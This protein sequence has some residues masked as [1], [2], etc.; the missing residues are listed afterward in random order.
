MIQTAPHPRLAAPKET[1]ESAVSRL[2]QIEV[3]PA[4]PE[5]EPVVANLLELYMHDFSEFLDVEL[6]T[7]G[8]FVYPHLS[9]YWLEPDR[10]LFLVTVDGRLAGVILVKKESG[11]RDNEAAWDMA[12]FFVVRKYR[13]RGVG[14]EAAHR[15][16][17][18][19][20]GRWQVRVMESNRPALGFW[21]RAIA[22]FAGAASQSVRIENGG[23][24]WTVF[25]F[26]SPRSE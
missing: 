9:S 23:R 10:H 7:D 6:G 21:D 26:E 14:T 19:L 12:E 8:R 20:P 5:Q 4:A 13:R 3:T 16:W 25:T 1:G 22:G 15:V 17:K 24:R 2:E 18:R 11:G